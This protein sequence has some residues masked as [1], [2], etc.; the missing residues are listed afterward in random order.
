VL[1]QEAAKGGRASVGSASYSVS[2]DNA[3][4]RARA[5]PVTLDALSVGG[6]EERA[7]QR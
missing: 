3:N 2:I 6:I 1:T 7:V 4:G 5:A